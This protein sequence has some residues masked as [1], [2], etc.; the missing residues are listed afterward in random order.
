MILSC[1]PFLM[2]YF[3]VYA[4]FDMIPTIRGSKSIRIVPTRK[5]FFEKISGPNVDIESITCD[6]QKLVDGLVPIIS[7]IDAFLTFITV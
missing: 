2:I 5:A 6:L 3:C 1:V 4:Y 7:D